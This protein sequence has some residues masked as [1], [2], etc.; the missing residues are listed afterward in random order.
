M[1]RLTFQE[2][3]IFHEHPCPKCGHTVKIDFPSP[4]PN[5]GQC[6]HFEEFGSDWRCSCGKKHYWFGMGW[7]DVDENGKTIWPKEKVPFS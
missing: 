5:C 4:C 6:Y 3:M 2:Q 7:L 1:D